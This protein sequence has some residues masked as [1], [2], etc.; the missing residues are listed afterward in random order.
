MPEAATEKPPKL[1]LECG[2]PLGPGRDDR[3]FCNELCKTEYHNKKRKAPKP[4]EPF[5][6]M[7]SVEMPTFKKIYDILLKNWT[8]MYNVGQYDGAVLPLRDFI[9]HGF[10]LKYFTSEVKEENGEVYRFC[11]NFGYRIIKNEEVHIVYRRE[12]TLIL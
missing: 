8:I 4:Y 6:Y 1:C 12:E 11:F 10:N 7:N 9:G 3:K 5:D 2:E